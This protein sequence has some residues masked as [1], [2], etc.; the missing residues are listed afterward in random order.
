MRAILAVLLLLLGVSAHAGCP[1][2]GALCQ[3][4]PGAVAPVN[5]AATFNGTNA[6]YV[7]D[8]ITLSSVNTLTV[9]VWVNWTTFAND[10]HL[11]YEYSASLGTNAGSFYSD[12]D[13][14]G[15]SAMSPAVNS[16]STGS[17]ISSVNYP[18]TTASTWHHFVHIWKL[19]DNLPANQI[20]L[21]IDGV[22]QTQ[23]ATFPGAVA[24]TFGSYPLYVMS[25]AGTTL[26]AAGAICQMSIWVGTAL[27]A[28]NVTSLYGGASP[29][30]VAGGA[31]YFWHMDGAT[32][33]NLGSGGTV[34]MTPH[35]TGTTVAIPAPLSG[36]C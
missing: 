14:S 11:L 36:G 35:N 28:A 24:G 7:S 17:T 5:P 27:T 3:P 12:P 10:D 22:L 33:S 8:T 31:Q 18:R 21:Y 26:F 15:S 30:T 4:V 16:G 20:G 9:S 1:G 25:R 2:P 29:T 23:S 32:D 13:G 19:T 6:Y 34:N